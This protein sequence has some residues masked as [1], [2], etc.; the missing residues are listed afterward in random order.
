MF[1]GFNQLSIFQI[2]KQILA[3]VD[4][5]RMASGK[6]I[7][8]QAAIPGARKI[9]LT[10]QPKK[11]AKAKVRVTQSIRVARRF[12]FKPKIPIRV[13]FK[14]TYIVFKK[15]YILW[16]FGHLGYFMT[17]LCSFGTFFLVLVSSTKKTSCNP[18][19]DLAQALDFKN[20]FSMYVCKQTRRVPVQLPFG[21]VDH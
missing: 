12:V 3:I 5:V 18:A 6:Q 8:C 9:R 17:I 19:I 1:F 2:V 10:L 14:E 21:V 4:G 11:T 20:S 7:S 16:P 13:K 15:I